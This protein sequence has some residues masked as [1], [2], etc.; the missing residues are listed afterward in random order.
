MPKGQGVFHAECSTRAHDVEICA[1]LCMLA[2]TQLV[3]ELSLGSY[4]PLIL[5]V[6]GTS[7]SDESPR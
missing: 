3:D 4:K 7:E 5:E 6:M 2:G 1:F